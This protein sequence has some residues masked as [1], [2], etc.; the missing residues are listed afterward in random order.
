MKVKHNFELRFGTVSLFI[1]ITAVYSFAEFSKT[2]ETYK[3]ALEVGKRVGDN[4]VVNNNGAWYANACA[5]YGLLL[6]AEASGNQQYITTAK[7]KYE[8][9]L[10]GRKT[11]PK[12]TGKFPVDANIFGIWPF[13]LYQQTNDKIYIKDGQEL[14]DEEYTPLKRKD[15]L[16]N[17]TRFWCDDLYMIGSLQIQAYH[18]LKDPKY[19]DRCA[20]QIMAYA[21]SLQKKD[22]GL[23]RHAYNTEVH[24]GRANGWVAA[25]LT[26]ALLKMPTEHLK[27]DT[28]LYTYRFMMN[29]LVLHQAEKGMWRQVIDNKN[30]WFESSCSA[31]FI[32]A[33]ATG[34]RNG[35][36]SGEKYEKAVEKGWLALIEYVDS[37]GRLKDICEG[38]EISADESY[39]L[40]RQKKVGDMH[41]QAPV[42]WAATAIIKLC[43]STTTI[44]QVDHSA[45][46]RN[47]IADNKTWIRT[48]MLGQSINSKRN[49]SGL[50]IFSH[51]SQQNKY[52][53]Q[54]I[55]R[56]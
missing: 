46:Y 33:L 14:A 26:E 5:W 34:V 7:N 2:S 39:Y 42:L 48:N 10:T 51:I 6:F 28:L 32:F 55:L 9:Y 40:K 23:F 20:N 54:K 47:A 27:R 43:E 18:A 44:F 24:W 38:T 19:A 4:V 30:A 8:P 11:P 41:G 22:D 37:Q 52:Q 56:Y 13:E 25:A 35:W 36:I 1:L 3:T 17:Y 53:Y 45:P 21:D 50:L 29:G 49:S 15:G 31:M 12:G 16:C